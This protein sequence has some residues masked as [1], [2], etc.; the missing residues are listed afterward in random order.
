MQ[1]NEHTDTGRQVPSR[2]KVNPATILKCHAETK[3]FPDTVLTLTP[4]KV[5]TRVYTVVG[6]KYSALRVAAAKGYYDPLSLSNYTR[7]ASTCNPMMV[8]STP[9]SHHCATN[10]IQKLTSYPGV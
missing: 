7:S 6:G 10:G 3:S 4:R 5:Q 2:D 8:S 1:T 9:G